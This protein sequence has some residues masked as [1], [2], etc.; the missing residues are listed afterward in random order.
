MK[1]INISVTLD[2]EPDC[3]STEDLIMKVI[4]YLREVGCTVE[5]IEIKREEEEDD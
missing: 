5:K 3:L 2:K 1:T 4:A